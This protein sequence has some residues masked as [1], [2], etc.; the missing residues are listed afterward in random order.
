MSTLWL[1]KYPVT[2]NKYEISR[3]IKIIAES[4]MVVAQA[5]GKKKWRIIVCRVSILQVERILEIDG[6]ITT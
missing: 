1:V 2:K 5:G 4:R 6:C 3:V